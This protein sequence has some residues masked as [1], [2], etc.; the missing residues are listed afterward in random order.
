VP[1][2]RLDFGKGGYQGC[3]GG[4]GSDWYVENVLEV[5]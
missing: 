1:P 4:N 5:R 2:A 3:R